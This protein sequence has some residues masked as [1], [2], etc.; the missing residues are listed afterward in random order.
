MAK[1]AENWADQWG[2]PPVTEKK[3]ENKI[4]KKLKGVKKLAS[5]GIVKAKAVAVVG[6]KKV[7]V[8]AKMVAVVGA[9]KAKVGAKKVK[10][11]ASKG[12]KFVKEQYKKK[13]SSK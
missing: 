1:G 4:G 13:K 5:A 8:G 9:K 10:I 6:A 12:F 3:K 2:S 11:G 7:K